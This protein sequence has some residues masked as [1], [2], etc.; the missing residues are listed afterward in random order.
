MWSLA[1]GLAS[2]PEC[3]VTASEEVGQS[4]QTAVTP[5]LAKMSVASVSAAVS[6]FRSTWA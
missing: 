3:C 2:Q 4:I 6:A 1:C 5:A